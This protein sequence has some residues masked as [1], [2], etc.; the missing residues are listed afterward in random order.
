[1]SITK[2]QFEDG[3][4]IAEKCW[5]RLMEMS[6][7][8]DFGTGLVATLCIKA[9]AAATIEDLKNQQPEM[10]DIIQKLESHL[11]DQLGMRGVA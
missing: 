7:D 3:L 4:K 5:H 11:K 6:P 2:E 9:T 8:E 10:C 1:M